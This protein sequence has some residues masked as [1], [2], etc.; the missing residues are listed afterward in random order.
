MIL[1]LG[2]GENS[3]LPLGWWDA[4]NFWRHVSHDLK[5]TKK[6]THPTSEPNQQKSM[7][8][9]LISFFVATNPN[10]GRP[11]T[12]FEETTF[13]HIPCLHFPPL[14][15]WNHRFHHWLTQTPRVTQTLPRV[16]TREVFGG[17][18]WHVFI[19]SPGI[20]Y[21]SSSNMIQLYIYA[22]GGMLN[23]TSLNQLFSNHFW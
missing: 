13:G 19:S 21:E 4:L 14:D 8:K 5:E 22:T 16:S 20:N 6:N 17:H 12:F 23:S 10:H 2:W 1:I 3:P 7:P 9:L 11:A 18:G 15:P